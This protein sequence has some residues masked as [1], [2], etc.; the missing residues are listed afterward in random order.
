LEGD[1]LVPAAQAG[2]TG[3]LLGALLAA[4]LWLFVP[5]LEAHPL[6]I[7]AGATLVI[8]AVAWLLLLV[9]TRKLLWNIERL[10]G[11]D[12]DG[13]QEIGRPGHLVFVNR[14]RAKQR[15]EKDRKEAEW[16][17]F[18]GF[19]SRLGVKGTTLA[20]WES[21]IGRDRY[22]EFRDALID[23]GFA[24]WRSYKSNGTPNTT[25]GWYLLDEPEDILAQLQIERT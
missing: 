25:Q 4:L 21:E 6:A 5:D 22:N 18:L 11:Q 16:R 24:R 17:A 1:F 2:L 10:T 3:L 12:L 20:V 7:W 13:D 19:V 8:V 15:A 14:E 23:Y 9:D